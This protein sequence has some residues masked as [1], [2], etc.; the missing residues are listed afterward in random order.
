MRKAKTHFEQVSLE[1]VK[2]IA[3]QQRRDETVNSDSPVTVESPGTK[4]E[5]ADNNQ[6]HGLQYPAWQKLCQEALMELDND[7]LKKR[8]ADAEAAV[9]LRLQ[10]LAYCGDGHEER[11]ALLDVSSSLRFLKRDVLKFP[12]WE[13]S[14]KIQSD[15]SNA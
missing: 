7:K 8:V 10:E 13:Y 9:F 11:Q 6:F 2:K 15:A 5:T 14:G 12:D 4:T 3:E 1:I